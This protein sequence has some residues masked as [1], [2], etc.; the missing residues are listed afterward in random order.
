MKH[1]Y[2][3]QVVLDHVPTL[4]ANYVTERLRN[5]TFVSLPKRYLYFGVAKAACTQMKYLLRNLENAPPMELFTRG[6]PV[7]RRDMFVHARENV[8]LPSL[9]ALDNRTQREILESP[10]YFRMTVVRNPYTRLVSAWKNKILFCEPGAEEIYRQ[11]KGHVPEF[12][13]KKALVSFDEFIGYIANNCDLRTCD[14]HWRRQVDHLLFPAFNFSCTAKVEQ[15]AEG[16]RKFEQ[17]LGI[18]E[19]LVIEGINVSAPVR[20]AIYTQ[21]LAD[22][23]YSLYK[24]DF[25]LLGYSRD[26]WAAVE[27]NGTETSRKL[28]VSEE[29][30]RHEI[31][32][33]N[34]I[35]SVLYR[36]RDELQN[37][38]R[39]VSRLHLL[40]A[41]N[42]LFE[43]CKLSLKYLSKGKVHVGRVFSSVSLT[44]VRE[45]PRDRKPETLQNDAS[46]RGAERL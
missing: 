3:V 43:L 31:V 24:A 26:S 25:E 42:G 2:A 4:K 39:R 23:V 33:R 5:S 18:S 13:A 9:V 11:V 16:L 10:D 44:R 15:M 12:D 46:N 32:E 40:T 20:G 30:F 21:E 35:I 38:V 14:P 6:L 19:P 29:R 27:H 22:K 34:I 45:L 28:G 41:I 37:Q 17:H 36:E 1:P 7:T 8:P